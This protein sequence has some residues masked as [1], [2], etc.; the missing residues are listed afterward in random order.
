M[1]PPQ[2][3]DLLDELTSN[4]HSES[5]SK[6]IN[7]GEIPL[8]REYV[9]IESILSAFGETR[10]G[11]R[12]RSPSKEAWD[13]ITIDEYEEPFSFYQCCISCGF[14]PEKL[15]DGLRHIKRKFY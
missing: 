10:G 2:L 9:L 4:D 6:C 3:F 8:L 14:N 12:K 15:L 5:D 11:G 13:W 1:K 7:E